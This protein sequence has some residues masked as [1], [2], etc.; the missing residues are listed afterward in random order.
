[1][2]ASI[3]SCM[4]VMPADGKARPCWD[5]GSPVISSGRQG[6]SAWLCHEK[7]VEGPGRPALWGESYGGQR[8]AKM[9][10]GALTS[11]ELN[12]CPLPCLDDEKYISLVPV[13]SISI[14]FAEFYRNSFSAHHFVERRTYS[15]QVFSPSLWITLHLRG[16]ASC[17]PMMIFHRLPDNGFSVSPYLPLSVLGSSSGVVVCR[18]GAMDVWALF[19]LRSSQMGETKFR[20]VHEKSSWTLY[21]SVEICFTRASHSNPLFFCYILFFFFSSSFKLHC[22]LS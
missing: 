15:R 3:L 7:P 16:G 18:L 12:C 10:A 6:G 11:W 13:H 8:A 22:V 1:M 21:L 20:C 4:E 19:E 2:Y 9:L 17:V 14:I 5:R